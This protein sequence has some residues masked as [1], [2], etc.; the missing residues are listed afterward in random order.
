MRFPIRP[1]RGRWPLWLSSSAPLA[2]FFRLDPLTILDPSATPSEYSEAMTSI[3]VG[4]TI[5]ITG[6]NRHPRT[7]ELLISSIDLEGAH[8]V[9]IG[10][11]DGSTSV[12][13]IALAGDFGRYTIADRYLTLQ[14]V[15][16]DS[17]TVL[18]DNDDVCVLV[19]GH[20]FA[21]WPSLSSEV[22]LLYRRLIDRARSLL[23]SDGFEVLLLGPQARSLIEDDDR[24]S[25]RTHDVFEPWDGDQPDVIKVANLLRRLYFDDEQLASALDALHSSLPDGGH[26]VIVDNPRIPDTPPRAGVWRRESDGFALVAKAGDPEIEDLVDRVGASQR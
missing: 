11:S 14:A 20:R 19:V 9:D 24:V 1:I 21:A 4:G 5:K 26:L 15:R 22:A 12:D 17:H 3:Y 2:R 7:D 6:S 23:R 18:F 8:I 13:L 25:Y 16:L 10:A